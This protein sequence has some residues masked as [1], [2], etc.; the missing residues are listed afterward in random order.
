MRARLF[1]IGLFA[2]LVAG[3]IGTASASAAT[4]FVVTSPTTK[5]AVPGKVTVSAKLN[6]K[7]SA[8]IVSAKFYANGKRITTDNRYPFK[9]KRGVKFDTRDL[10]TANPTVRLTVTFKILK[11][12]GK[13][14]TR[15]LKRNVRIQIPTN[16]NPTVGA[17]GT[18][19]PSV[20]KADTT[21]PVV[22]ITAP[23]DG[24][25]TTATSTVLHFLATDD[26]G[27][28]PNCNAMEGATIPLTLGANVVTVT[29][30][31]GAGNASTDSSSVTRTCLASSAPS[32]TMHGYPLAFS[33]Q[34]DCPTL[35]DANWNTQRVDRIGGAT[36]DPLSNPYNGIEGAAYATSN[37]SVSDG[38][39]SL[40]LSDT[41]APGSASYYT[42]ST[43]M[44][45]TKD[46]F[47][48]KYGYIESRAM[49]PDCNGCWPAFWIMPDDNSWPPEIDIFEYIN[50]T[51]YQKKYP[52]TVFHWAPDG[53]ENDA[54]S[55][56]GVPYEH[57]ISNPPGHP[58]MSEER[59][60][61]R[62]AGDSGDYTN[63]WHTYGLH[64]TP[65]Y[66][67]IYLD[68]QLSGRVDGASKIPQK[69]MYPIFQMAIGKPENGVPAA[70]NTLKVDYLH[71]YSSDT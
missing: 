38:A 54:Q 20:P 23:L 67:E 49:V 58:E 16:G 55:F 70:G 8:R 32:S 17:K 62:P 19:S 6:A 13:L 27:I 53:P 15:T 26:S 21:D 30:T 31:D 64:W 35:N 46:K 22:T 29:C 56:N 60:V 61:V 4:K 24:S 5:A 25:T 44:V 39:L 59:Y 12:N 47:K 1:A 42:R 51:G 40:K 71:V 66:V 57:V 68:G 69:A 45:N 18:T 2:L 28:S 50:F 52:H 34:F 48:F 3:A 10:P 33:D 41:K 36:T 9:V 43:G 63:Q 37:V 14:K 11:S 7:R 65:T